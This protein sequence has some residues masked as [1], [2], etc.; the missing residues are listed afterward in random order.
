MKSKHILEI[1]KWEKISITGKT[2]MK[3]PYVVPRK[4][5]CRKNKTNTCNNSIKPMCG[6]LRMW[7][8]FHVWNECK[9]IYKQNIIPMLAHWETY[10][11][12]LEE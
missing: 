12:T 6:K 11:Y 7:L 1:N 2:E 5:F 10:E 3:I 4:I 9:N 8:N